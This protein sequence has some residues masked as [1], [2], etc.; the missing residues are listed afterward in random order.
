M[1]ISHDLK[2][3]G[4]SDSEIR[5]YLFLLSNGLSTPPQ[6]AVGTKIAR[7]HCYGLLKSLAHQGLVHVQHRG[8][9]YAYLA[10]DPE[11]L[12][13]TLDYKRAK[14][15]R[16]L[17]DL[18]ALYT[19]QKNKPKITFYEGKE[20][21]KEIFLLTLQ[22]QEIWGIGSTKQLA[23]VLPDFFLTYQQKIRAQEIV[24]HDL[25]T[26]ASKASGAQIQ[27][28]MRGFYEVNYLP[29][30][31]GEIPTNILIWENN[32]ALIDLSEPIFGTVLANSALA[33][34]FK[35]LFEVMKDKKT[36]SR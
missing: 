1:P 29:Q 30:K 2:E 24:F 17:P 26:S 27:E 36:D 22:S 13:R 19:T 16:L 18:R 3:F 10:S 15:T 23:E 32:L 7:T 33:K 28:I 34:T 25:L 5:V 4:L 35:I 21:V 6:I 31:Y 20:Q 8:K 12:A 11:S 9:R 14:L